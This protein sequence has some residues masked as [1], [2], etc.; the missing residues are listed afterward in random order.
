MISRH[1]RDF[2]ELQGRNLQNK[3]ISLVSFN[4]IVTETL[5]LVSYFSRDNVSLK[6]NSKAKWLHGLSIRFVQT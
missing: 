6:L 5:K 3:V 4:A 1:R 2:Y